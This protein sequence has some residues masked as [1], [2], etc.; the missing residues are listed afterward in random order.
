M[1]D[2]LEVPASLSIELNVD[3]PHCG[4]YFDL[5]EDMEDDA[6]SDLLQ[7]ACPSKVCWS[8]KHKEFKHETTCKECGK[9]VKIQEIEW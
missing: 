1:S 2:E 3:C 7:Y 4:S 9:I 8:E 5:L 6:W